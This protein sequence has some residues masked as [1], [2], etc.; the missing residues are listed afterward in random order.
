MDRLGS[1]ILLDPTTGT[2]PRRAGG[3]RVWRR[4]L[5]G[6]Q[7]GGEIIFFHLGGRRG[8]ERRREAGGGGGRKSREGAACARR[9]IRCPSPAPPG[10]AGGLGEGRQDGGGEVGRAGRRCCRRHRRLRSSRLRSFKLAPPRRSCPGAGSRGESKSFPWPFSP[11]TLPLPDSLPLP[12]S[13][14][15]RAGPVWGDRH[16][17][18]AW[19]LPRRSPP[20]AAAR[21]GALGAWSRRRRRCT[22]FLRSS[23]QGPAVAAHGA[24]GLRGA[25]LSRAGGT[26]P[27]TAGQGPCT[28][29]PLPSPLWLPPHNPGAAGPG[30]AGKVRFR[31]FPSPLSCPSIAPGS[32]RGRE[33]GDRV[34][35]P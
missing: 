28:L 30:P 32:G 33:A 22:R 14:G 10:G 15:G 13:S 6:G 9:L 12:P 16:L 11:S 19:G 3:V 34:V 26:P 29:T 2:G 18:P 1:G 17:S 21:S 5:G 4:K 7:D 8:G 25:P 23:A 31:S 35:L 20:P 24:F 27:W